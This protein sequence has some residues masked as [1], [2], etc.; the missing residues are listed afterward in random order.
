MAEYLIPN[1][2]GEMIQVDEKGLREYARNYSPEKGKKAFKQDFR[3]ANASRT[4][5]ISEVL[6]LLEA[7][8]ADVRRV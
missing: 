2:E 7:Q 5:P 6:D 1:E 4:R 8:G 3:L